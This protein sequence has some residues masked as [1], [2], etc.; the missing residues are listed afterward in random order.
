MKKIFYFMTTFCVAL[1]FTSCE[2]KDDKEYFEENAAQRSETNIDNVMKVLQSAPNGWLM[3][4]YG[5]LGYGGFNVMV[6]FDGDQAT[7]ASEQIGPSHKAGIGDDG[8][9]VTSTSHFKLEQSMGTILSFDDYNPTF[10]YFSMPNNPDGIGD[11]SEGMYGDFEF[12]VMKCT[13]DSIVL[14]GKKHQNR[15]YMVPIPADKAW[16]EII[17]DAEETESFMSSRYYTLEGSD[18]TDTVDIQIVNQGR[19]LVFTYKDST[20]LTE[21]VVA[22]YIVN[23][24]GFEFYNLVKVN[25]YELDGLYKGDTDEYFVF[26]NNP[27]LRLATAL[28]TLVES[29]TTGPWYIRYSTLGDY[30][31]PKWDAMMETLKTAGTNKTE[32][33]IYYGIFGLYNN[34]LT[35]NLIA[36]A[37]APYQGFTFSD[38]NETGDQLTI[39]WSPKLNNRDGR[40]YFSKY[41]WQDAMEPFYGSSERSGKYVFGSGRTFKL[42]CDYPR[43]PTYITLTDVNEPTNVITL[44]ADQYMFMDSSSGYYLDD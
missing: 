34:R 22:P 18:R 8:K 7:V 44:W 15:I 9:V 43:K 39:K 3:E 40:D 13:P 1:A 14:S 41:G 30:A 25:G 31:Q 23:K 20:D 6:K 38:V 16:E 26:K 32:I 28:P 37:D 24:E 12:R 27:N 4:Y 5:A 19:C 10:H 42:S 11:T 29:L 21:T 35:A 36:G 2:L 17:T 33:K